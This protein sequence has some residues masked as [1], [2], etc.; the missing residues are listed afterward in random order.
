MALLSQLIFKKNCSNCQRLRIQVVWITFLI[1]SVSEAESQ[2]SITSNGFTY[3]QNFNT[4][5]TSGTNLTWTN[6]STLNGWHA[7]RSSGLITTYNTDAGGSATGALYSYG[8]NTSVNGIN[9]RALGSLTTGTSGDIVYGALFQNNSGGLIQSIT[10]SFRAEQWRKALTAYK[11]H[12]RVKMSYRIANIVDVTAAGLLANSFTEIPEAFLITLDTITTAN[13]S[14]DGNA[15]ATQDPPTT[16]FA[17][18]S[19]TF[20]VQLANGQQLFIRFF[21]KDDNDSDIPAEASNPIAG[22]EDDMVMALD[23]FAVTFSSAT[24][25]RITASSDYSFFSYM[26]QGTLMDIPP[27]GYI[28]PTPSDLTAWQTILQNFYTE[29]WNAVAPAA[30]TYQLA[31]F[32][33][34]VN[35]RRYFILRKQNLSTYFW[36]T[37]AIA[38]SPA[39]NVLVVQTPHPIIDSFS[40]RQGA[41]VFQFIGAYAYMVAGTSRCASPTSSPCAGTTAVCGGTQPFRTSDVPHYDATVFHV[42][43]TTM[44]NLDQFRVFVQLHGFGM[45]AGEPHFYISCGTMNGNLKSVP[46]YPVQVREQFLAIDPLWDSWITHV[47]IVTTLGARDNVQGRFLNNYPANICTELTSS[48]PPTTV[49]NRFLHIEQFKAVREFSIYYDDIATAINN[50]VN[51][52]PYLTHVPIPNINFEYTQNFDG[53]SNVTGNHTW[54]NNLTLPGWYAFLDGDPAPAYDAAIDGLFSSYRSSNGST[55]SV[56]GPYSYGTAGSSERALG[57]LNLDA[58]GN[59]A[60]GVLFQNNTGLHIDAISMQYRAEQWRR[61]DNGSSTP[62]RVKLSYTINNAAT[63]TALNAPGLTANAIM[64]NSA[65]TNVP[66]GDLITLNNTAVNGSLDG[67]ASGNFTNISVTFNVDLPAGQGIFIR[68]YD[69][70]VTNPNRAMAIDDLHVTFASNSL[71][72]QWHSFEVKN[73]QGSPQL[74]WAATEEKMCERYEVERSINGK[75]FYLVETKACQQSLL[76]NRYTFI[77]DPPHG[78]PVVYYRIAQYDLDRHVTY[79][80]IRA[81]HQKKI[82]A[83]EMH[84]QNGVLEINANTDTKLQSIIIL[85]ILGRKLCTT[86]PISKDGF[87]YRIECPNLAGQV[88]IVKAVFDNDVYVARIKLNG[89]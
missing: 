2:I 81:F 9:D 85:D 79:S 47:D 40:D 45:S 21:D 59:I 15:N 87:R 73:H 23:D 78:P 55:L 68:F 39:N 82:I 71:P 36:G 13:A 62:Q 32:F 10:L 26:D 67:N 11:G 22:N 89:S 65:F 30:Y 16:N 75:D 6:G 54:G 58:S 44:A 48:T 66:A 57:S 25:P 56:Y 8:S 3:S 70:N 42:A 1:F 69:E 35:S 29:N 63:L 60:Y 86:V 88:I 14:M 5:A 84:Y 83:P 37:Y 64:N 19:V 76:I 50:V 31:E 53:L 41:A 38:I 49:T 46:D 20:P 74:Y 24:V 34:Q 61:A 7:A 12:Q 28:E 72:V 43:T 27:A 51:P 77:D 33:D 4:L 17:N 18:V 80:P 52:N